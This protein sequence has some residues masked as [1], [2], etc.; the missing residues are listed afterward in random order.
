MR[1]PRLQRQIWDIHLMNSQTNEILDCQVVHVG[2]A[3]N[4]SIME[5][6]GLVALLNGLDDES[7]NIRSLSTDRHIQIRKYIRE[8]RKEILHHSDVWHVSKSIKKKLFKVSRKKKTRV[9]CDLGSRQFAFGG[10]VLHAR[11][12]F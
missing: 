9:T 7:L 6:E 8:E 5:K 1:F 4:S 12:A 2:Q 10:A 11:L 3:A